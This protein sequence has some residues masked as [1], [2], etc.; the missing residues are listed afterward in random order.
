M[1]KREIHVDVEVS[2]RHPREGTCIPPLD[3][4]VPDDPLAP[5]YLYVAVK[6]FGPGLKPEDLALLFK[7]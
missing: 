7:R 4:E 1:D 5:L 3:G 6:D 2:F